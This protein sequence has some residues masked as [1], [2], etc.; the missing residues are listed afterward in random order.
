M[1]FICFEGHGGHYNSALYLSFKVLD[2]VLP[3]VRVIILFTGHIGAKSIISTKV[4][5]GT[6]MHHQ[7]FICLF[8]LPTK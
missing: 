1:C 4:F 6:L 5:L 2:L 7:T 3:L 8:V